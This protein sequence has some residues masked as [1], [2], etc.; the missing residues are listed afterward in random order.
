MVDE[1]LPQP[2]ADRPASRVDGHVPQPA[3][4]SISAAWMSCSCASAGTSAVPPLRTI[5]HGV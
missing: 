1:A 5:T 4:A 2:E 3:Y